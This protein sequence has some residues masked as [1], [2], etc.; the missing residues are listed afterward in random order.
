MNRARRSRVE[1]RL[2]KIENELKNWVIR[3][4]SCRLFIEDKCLRSIASMGMGSTKYGR[5]S[6]V[7]EGN[8]MTVSFQV[9]EL[10][11]SWRNLLPWC[12]SYRQVIYAD[13]YMSSY[14][15]GVKRFT[16]RNS[17]LHGHV[18]IR[19]SNILS[20]C[21]FLI[22]YRFS[23]QHFILPWWQNLRNRVHLLSAFYMRIH[24]KTTKAYRSCKG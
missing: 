20:W 6:S 11:S 2:F 8:G 21:P 18:W 10:I 14:K 1:E 12:K 24:D 15:V 17:V 5:N 22:Y 19:P 23:D 13:D 3:A 4:T 16:S 7:H 9:R